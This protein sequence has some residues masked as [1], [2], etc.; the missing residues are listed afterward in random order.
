MNKLFLS[1]VFLTTLLFSSCFEKTELKEYK[2]RYLEPSATGI[3]NLSQLWKGSEMKLEINI[4]NGI[5]NIWILNDHKVLNE[6]NVFDRFVK[7][8]NTN[9]C[10][11]VRN[12]SVFHF[13]CLSLDFLVNE[14]RDSLKDIK[15]WDR[16]LIN[17]W[18]LKSELNQ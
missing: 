2:S 7:E 4:G 16:K 11:I 12:D 10:M 13:D 9:K 14:S 6:I 5:K 8:K 1:F 3:V 17:F 15:Q 18:K